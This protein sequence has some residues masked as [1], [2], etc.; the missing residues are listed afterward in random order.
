M[1]SAS[2]SQSSASILAGLHIGAISTAPIALAVAVAMNTLS[3]PSKGAKCGC[4]AYAAIKLIS[5][6]V[7]FEQRLVD[8]AWLEATLMGLI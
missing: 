2:Q 6:E 1:D 7:G 5:G 4:A 3:L 8:K